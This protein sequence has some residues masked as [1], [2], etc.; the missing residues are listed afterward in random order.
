MS[1]LEIFKDVPALTEENCEQ[2]L[3]VYENQYRKAYYNDL[4][5][6][7]EVLKK[8]YKDIVTGLWYC[9]ETDIDGGAYFIFRSADNV[10]DQDLDDIHS[11]ILPFAAYAYL[12]R[13]TETDTQR[14]RMLPIDE[15]K[16]DDYIY[17][18][19]DSERGIG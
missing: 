18:V 19:Y 10:T 1:G 15:W 9:Q 5:D 8:K 16:A 6:C 11:D 4:M 13:I 3:V 7:V 12:Y 14:V 2:V 17:A